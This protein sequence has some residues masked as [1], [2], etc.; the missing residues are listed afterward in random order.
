MRI[1]EHFQK[2]EAK[3]SEYSYLLCWPEFSPHMMGTLLFVPLTMKESPV[4]S[5]MAFANEN[6]M[7]D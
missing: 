1:L 5:P 6:Q 4:Q 3:P 7:L 2:T